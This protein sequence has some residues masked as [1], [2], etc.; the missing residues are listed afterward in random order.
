VEITW[1]P[2]A[3]DEAIGALLEHC[4]GVRRVALAVDLPWLFTKRVH[5]PAVSLEARRE[6]LRLEPDR[7]FPVRAEEIVP[8]VR[9]EDDLVF[10]ARGAQLAGWIGVI[11]RIAPVELVEPGPAALAR[12]LDRSGVKDATVVLDEGEDGIGLLELAGGRLATARRLF[13]DRA[14]LTAAFVGRD[15]AVVFLSPWTDERAKILADEIPGLSLRPLPAGTPVPAPFFAAYGAALGISQAPAPNET[16]AAPELWRRIRMRQWRERALAGAACA[17]AGLILVASLGAWRGR[18]TRAL[19]AGLEALRA[20][21][22]PVL[23]LQTEL[24]TLGQRAQAIRTIDASRPDPLRVLLALSQHLPAGA[25][26]RGVHTSDNDWQ[27]DGYAPN[28]AR[29]IAALGGVPG[30]TNV[31]FLAATNRAQVGADQL[32]SFALAFRFV[33]AP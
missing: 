15:A 20:Q 27:I 9:A 16:L 32:E 26:L 12:A 1:D 22:A 29:V 30:I 23:A 21:A 25:F 17:I 31:H 2:A 11:E 10:A 13:R 3:P 28:A 33:P 5:L 18:S 19:D 8:A 4:G 24:E 7:F 14:A 6:I